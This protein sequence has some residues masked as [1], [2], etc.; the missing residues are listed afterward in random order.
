[1]KGAGRARG[2]FIWMILLIFVPLVS[3]TNAQAETGLSAIPDV[4]VWDETNQNLSLRSVIGMAGGGPVILLPVY[5]RCAASCPVL[6][7]KL[8]EETARM[9]SGIPYRVLLISFDP[10]ETS[11]SLRMFREHERVPASWVIVRADEGEIRRVFD[12]FRYTV[13]TEGGLLVHPN[14]IFLL[15]HDLNWRATLVGVDWG[16]TDLQKNLSRIEAR[17]LV[18]WIAMNPA[19][20]ALIGFGGLVL[21]LGL[22]IGWLIVRRPYRHSVPT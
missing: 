16:S 13:M 2:F 5:T 17:G 3:T 10:S 8:E 19:K 11:D 21:S 12:F 15:D 6:T 18:G 14:E 7:R 22:I 1:M 9:G 20:L 4:R